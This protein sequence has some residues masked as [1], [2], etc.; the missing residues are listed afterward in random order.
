MRLTGKVALVTGSGRG[1]GK[2]IALK[3]ASE[4]ADI[5]VNFFRNREPAEETAEEIRQLGR[6]ALVVKANVAE[7]EHLDALF[8][9]I[10]AEFGRLD[11][12]VNN[13]ASGYN[14]GVL[15]QRPKG[16]DW[17]MN[18]NARAALFCSQQAVRL[19][20]KNDEGGYIINISS[21]G[22]QRVLPEY[23]LVGVSKAALEALTR[24]LAV[25]LAPLNIRVNAVSAGAVRTDALQHFANMR[26][27]IEE[28]LEEIAQHTPAGRIVE[29][30]DIAN[31]VCFLCTPDA[32]M[33]RGQVIVIDGGL[34]LKF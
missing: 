2:A 14:R 21:L 33:I 34:S 12:L 8:E 31:T 20:Q 18:I 22:A 15:E 16:W 10:E 11:I 3:L 24:Y 9:A 32:E 6:R 29:A 23:V 4:G 27:V 25:E 17:T 1:I 5:V 19:M 30:E 28:K 13:A 7:V 26:D